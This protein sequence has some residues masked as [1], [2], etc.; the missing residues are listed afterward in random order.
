MTPTDPTPGRATGAS[1]PEKHA[2]LDRRPVQRVDGPHSL[3][4]LAVSFGVTVVATRLYLSLAGYPQIGHGEFHLA[5]ALWGG[6]L[7]MVAATS[8]LLWSNGWVM[9]TAAVCAG[10]GSGLFVDEV[11]KFI[12][13]RNDYFTPLAAPIIYLVFL[14]V[15]AVVVLARRARV[16]DAR[17]VAYALVVGLKDV[18]D[19]PIRPAERAALLSRLHVLEADAARPD[20][21]ALARQ[22][23]PVVEEAETVAPRER[24]VRTR[25]ALATFERHVLPRPVYRVILVL[26]AAAV[27]LVSLIGLAV[28]VALAS[29]SPRFRVVVDDQSVPPGSRPPALLIASFGE[30]VVGVA[31]L[32]SA[33]ALLVGRDRFGL[34]VGHAGL[35]FGLSAVNV[36]LGYISAEMV[37]VVVVAELAL[38]G[39]YRSYRTRFGPSARVPAGETGR[40]GGAGSH[41]E[42][43]GAPMSLKSLTAD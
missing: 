32:L 35:V 26:G 27:G 7:L 38:L 5:H 25:A 21:A 14:A 13:A 16:D 29:G 37:V 18:I 28:F 22:L 23:R 3:M 4:I 33:A 19:G 24:L 39:L 40:G 34:R 31:L 9:S 30:A 43:A 10:A 41:L 8:Q 1:V 42:S 11:G 15:L 12:T 36:M 2:R 17:S 6:L 20:L